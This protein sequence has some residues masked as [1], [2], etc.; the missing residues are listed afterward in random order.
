MRYLTNAIGRPSK[1]RATLSSLQKLLS[2]L[3]FS[4]TSNRCSILLVF[5]ET[6][7]AELL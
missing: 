1:R 6:V 5:Q 3:H 7:N 4:F 2:V